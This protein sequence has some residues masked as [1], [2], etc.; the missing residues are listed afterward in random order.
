MTKN[1]ERYACPACGYLVFSE[2]AGS[3]DICPICF[4][5]DDLVQLAFPDMAGGANKVSL[6]EAQNNFAKFGV[7]EQKF[8]GNVRKASEEDAR[9]DLWRPIDIDQDIYLHWEVDADRKHWQAFKDSPEP[10]L[11]YW[12]NDYWLKQP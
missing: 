6:I 2:P 1:K 7:S 3:Y 12:R 8:K 9:D 4:W 5:E 11:Y 10:L